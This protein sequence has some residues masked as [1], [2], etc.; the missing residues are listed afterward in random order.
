MPKALHGHESRQGI[1]AMKKAIVCAV[2]FFLSFQQVFAEQFLD[3]TWEQI[4]LPSRLWP[5]GVKLDEIVIIGYTGNSTAITIPGVINGLPVTEIGSSAF[6]GRGLTNIAIPDS[7]TEIGADAFANNHLTHIDF[8]DSV[9]EIRANAFANNRLT[10]VDL[11]SRIYSINSGAFA[12]NL[13]ASVNLPS[14]LFS[15]GAGAFARNCLTSIAIPDSVST[16]A[17]AAFAHNLLT[18]IVIHDGV[19]QIEYAAFAHNPLT[20]ITIGAGVFLVWEV[21][22]DG[23]SFDWVYT[24]GGKLAGTYTRAN[25]EST[26]WV[27]EE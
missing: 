1:I 13:L 14:G 7:V 11:P 25:P 26:E 27:R 15:I 6:A 5:D 24:D 16:I 17:P 23:G 10:S 2:L 4:I 8:P 18:N 21:L 3:F 9:R 20:S 12:N 22:G 19:R